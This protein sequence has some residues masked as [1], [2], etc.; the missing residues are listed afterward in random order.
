MTLSY[1]GFVLPVLECCSAVQCS[2]ADT[3]LELLDRAVRGA[4]FSTG[5]VFECDISH[6]WIRG[7]LVYALQDQVQPVHPFNGALPGPYVPARV[8]RGALGAHRYTYAPPRCRTLQYSKTFIPFSVSFWNNLANPS[9]RWCGTG[10]FQ[11]QGQCFFIGMSCSIPTIVFYSFSFFFSVHRLVL[12]GWVFG[13]I[14][15]ISL[16]LSLALPTFCNNNNYYYLFI[17]P[18]PWQSDSLLS[19][20]SQVQ[21]PGLDSNFWNRNQFSLTSG[22][23]C[24]KNSLLLWSLRLGR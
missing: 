6:W 12:W 14:G 15:C 18:S 7:S 19:Q 10:G 5:G 9:I 11:E 8:T 20:R 13:L 22:Q 4:R 17:R 3:H 16:S 24:L 1:W 21:I 2:A 23:G